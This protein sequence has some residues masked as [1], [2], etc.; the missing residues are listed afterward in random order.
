MSEPSPRQPLP[1]M[2]MRPSTAPRPAPQS[3]HAR[4]A[5]RQFWI[6]SAGANLAGPQAARV[7]TLLG[8]GMIGQKTLYSFFSSSPARKRRA[9]SPEPTDPETGVAAVTEESGDAAVRRAG[10]LSWGRRP[11]EEGGRKAEGLARRRGCRNAP[12]TG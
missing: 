6:A 9:R 11:G 7:R 8:F 2:R 3:E 5:W 1:H 10:D 12:P 4:A